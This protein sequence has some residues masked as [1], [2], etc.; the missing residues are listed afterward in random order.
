MSFRVWSETTKSLAV[1]LAKPG[2]MEPHQWMSDLGSMSNWETRKEQS[3][4]IV[5]APWSWYWTILNLDRRPIEVSKARDLGFG[6]G[7]DTKFK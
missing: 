7:Y 4:R 6:I 1:R 3:L 5:R 2:V